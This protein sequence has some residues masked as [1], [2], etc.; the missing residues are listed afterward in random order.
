MR[1]AV[2]PLLLS[3]A[4][5]LLAQ[6]PAAKPA[7][8][9]APAPAPAPT[10]A[11]SF[12]RNLSGVESEV[13]SALEAMPEEKFAF[14]PTN[15]E[16]K[17]VKTFAEQAKHIAAVNALLAAAILDEKPA[18]ETAGENGPEAVKTK[19][20]ILKYVKE[21]YAYL[22]KAMGSLTEANVLGLVKSPFGPGQGTRLG[23]AT[24]GISHGFDHYGQ[25]AVYLRMNGIIPPA[26]RR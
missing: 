23:F 9:S 5:P 3:L 16:F 20:E 10:F 15:G 19:A 12:D 1:L 8:A 25:I 26:S 14:A 17:G 7:P 18:M 6:A 21:S 22:H 11:S 2:L 4:G 13:V 24:I